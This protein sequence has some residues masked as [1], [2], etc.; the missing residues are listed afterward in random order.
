MGRGD[1]ST[2]WEIEQNG[3]KG[4]NGGDKTIISPF[5]YKFYSTRIMV[6]PQVTGTT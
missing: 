3:D 1:C 5:F 2:G 4:G 6:V